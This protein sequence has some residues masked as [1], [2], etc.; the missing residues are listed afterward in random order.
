MP[1][2]D[3]VLNSESADDLRAQ[4]E[5]TNSVFTTDSL[6][7]VAILGAAQEGERLVG[8]FANTGIEIAALCD[9]D[10][11]RVGQHIHG[12]EVAPSTILETLER[13]TP[14][15][16]ASHRLTG[17]FSW[18]KRL[19]FKHVAAFAL[20]QVLAPEKYS[21][22]M[23][24]DRWLEELID[25][26][27]HLIELSERLDDDFSRKVLDAVL[28]FRLTLNP[29]HLDDIVE[30]DLYDSAGLLHFSEDEVYVDGGAFD[31][32]TIQHFIERVDGKFDT[33][34]GFEPD[35]ETYRNLKKNFT[36]EPRVKPMN[37]GL[38]DRDTVLKFQDSGTR[39]S[40]FSADGMVLV[41]V[42][43]LDTVLH[44]ERASYIKMNIEGA[45]LAALDGASQTIR[46]W[47]PKLAI[48]AY[49]RP[50][51]LWA[52]AEKVDSINPE[53]KLYLR[54]HDGGVIETVLYALP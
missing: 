15:I 5:K 37:M 25:G 24:Y 17:A 43:D 51:D 33:V 21:P 36:H 10:A 13:D 35:P 14:I 50:A 3:R 41:P 47:K 9:E 26:R 53:Y 29:D 23:F 52:I 11:S 54:Q 20:L 12:V 30:W 49:H 40:I 1:W 46:T 18:L 42:M 38:Y 19:G 32:D 48:S 28:A 2:L 6:K 45:E 4:M 8:I 22:H 39:G 27:R 34:Y 44:G 16:V 7:R 31:G